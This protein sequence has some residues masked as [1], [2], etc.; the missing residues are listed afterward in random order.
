MVQA[1]NG[2]IE[3]GHPNAGGLR[4]LR[5][6][7]ML[8]RRIMVVDDDR[9]LAEEVADMLIS[10]GY[11]SEV[12]SDSIEASRRC[13]DTDPDLVL[14]DLRMPG[15][16]G[17]KLANEIAHRPETAHIPV[18]AMTGHY[19]S[20]SHDGLMHLCGIRAYLIKP[21]RPEDLLR[22]V[23]AVLSDAVEG[24]DSERGNEN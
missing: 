10:H 1:R 6:R 5:R 23:E 14:V 19:A 3:L 22:T 2:N 12:F 13:A 16:S 11:E 9:E 4:R 18:I 8:R 20:G 21:F 15:K 24:R 7:D 17:F